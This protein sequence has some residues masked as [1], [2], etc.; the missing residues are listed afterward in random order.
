MLEVTK[1]R[2]FTASEFDRILNEIQNRFPKNKTSIATYKNSWGNFT[3]D[4]TRLYQVECIELSPA[5]T[6]AQYG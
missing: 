5:E 6:K 4:T 2:E 1:E 3:I